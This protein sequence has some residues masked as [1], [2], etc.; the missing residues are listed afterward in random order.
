MGM[1]VS[2]EASALVTGAYMAPP[3]DFST[4]E[5]LADG[6]FRRTMKDGTVYSFNS[7]SWG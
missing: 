6:T 4:L 2:F 7:Q 1:E 5:R 3:G